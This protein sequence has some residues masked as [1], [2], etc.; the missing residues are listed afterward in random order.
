[1]LRSSAVTSSG[2]KGRV[3]RADTP[4]RHNGHP[5]AREVLW[6]LSREGAVSPRAELV[7]LIDGVE[8]EM[9]S[10]GRFRRRWR[11][12]RDVAAR[13]YADRVKARLVAR[14]YRDRRGPT[15]TGAWLE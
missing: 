14:G 3:I 10:G 1:M 11:F 7:G 9:F 8:L 4:P 5:E 15:R 12:L 13:R 6:M 2:G